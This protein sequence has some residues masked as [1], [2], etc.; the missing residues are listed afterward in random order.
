MGM[1]NT[2]KHYTNSG[3]TIVELLIVVVVIAVLAAISI[4]AYNG[5]TG[6]AK[7]AALQ[8]ELASQSKKFNIWKVQ[9]GE[10]YPSDLTTAR[11]A[12]MLVDNSSVTYTSYIANNTTTPANFC[13]TASRDGTEYSISSTATSPVLGRCVTNLVNNPNLETTGNGY[14]S[15]N[16][17]TWSRLPNTTL[18]GN[19][20]AQ[21]VLPSGG[22]VGSG[23]SINWSGNLAGWTA[24]TNYTLSLD[25]Y[26][27]VARQLDLTVQGTGVVGTPGHAYVTYTAGQTRRIYANFATN[28]LSGGF[29]INAY[30]VRT[31]SAA[32]TLYVKNVAMFV[33]STNYAYADG[34]SLGWFWNGE[35][36]NSTSTGPAVVS[37]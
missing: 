33:G 31:D 6:R 16:S 21:A 7:N 35:A 20:L 2:R 37:Q 23:L 32:G 19:Y 29:S 14:S 11:A 1:L 27:S 12:G 25:T 10:Q 5:I 24:D 8:S 18:G 34:N 26:S 9:N 28:A 36:N 4:V 30:L 3:F 13:A 22:T 15:A 17:A